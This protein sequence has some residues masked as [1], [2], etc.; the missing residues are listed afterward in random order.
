MTIPN[1]THVT[2]CPPII[3]KTLI[4]IGG[5]TCKPMIKGLLNKSDIPESSIPLDFKS[6]STIL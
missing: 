4:T 3:G 1:I 2:I 5:I 6:G